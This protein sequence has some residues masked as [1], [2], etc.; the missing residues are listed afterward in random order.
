MGREIRA[1]NMASD[2]V[3]LRA[4]LSKGEC[5]ITG[6]LSSDDIQVMMDAL[7]QLGAKSEWED[8]GGVY[9]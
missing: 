1:Y 9:W 8:G 4:A 6:L 2:R 7:P 3:L 5:G